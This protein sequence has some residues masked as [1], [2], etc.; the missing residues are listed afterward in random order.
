LGCTGR[1][2]EPGGGMSAGSGLTIAMDWPSLYACSIMGA[3]MPSATPPRIPARVRVRVRV[4]ALPLQG[5]GGEH[6][7]R[8]VEF[9]PTYA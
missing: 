5:R 6:N 8:K 1:S 7:T 3:P 2:M 9:S 4:R